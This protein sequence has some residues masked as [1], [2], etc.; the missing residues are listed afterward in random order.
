[1]RNN[2]ILDTCPDKLIITDYEKLINDVLQW[3]NNLEM[4]FFRICKI[5][6]HCNKAGMVFSP[7]KVQF[8]C[9]EVE[10]AGILISNIGLK[11]TRK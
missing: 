2:E 7:T 4:A 3:C 6:S 5:L 9:E 11:P 1:M 8:A 10:F